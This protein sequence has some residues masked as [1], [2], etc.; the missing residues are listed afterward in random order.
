[1]A[2]LE[3]GVA[4]LHAGACAGDQ[5]VQKSP[6]RV[7]SS[8][9]TECPRR[10][11][12]RSCSVCQTVLPRTAV[13]VIAHLAK[14]GIACTEGEAHRLLNRHLKSPDLKRPQKKNC[15]SIARFHPSWDVAASIKVFHAEY[16]LCHSI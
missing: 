11:D 9:R 3:D 5:P 16:R 10:S 1:M 14:H 15:R 2:D 8:D 12:E 6:V 13:D 4:N 7:S